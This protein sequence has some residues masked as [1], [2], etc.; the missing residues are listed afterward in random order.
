MFLC[1]FSQCQR[2]KFWAVIHAKHGRIATV[3]RDPVKHPDHSWGW[4]IQIYFNRQR[5]TVKVIN[6]IERAKTTP[7]DQGIMHK[8]NRPA[9]VQRFRRGQ[10]RRVTHRQPLFALT[11]KIQLQQTINTVDPFVIPHVSLPP[12][13]LKK[14]RKTVSWIPFSC[15]LQCGNNGFVTC[16]IRTVMINR[17]AQVQAPAGLTDTESECRYQ[18][19]DQL[20]LKGWF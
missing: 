7:T 10:W 16:V 1:P 11:A 6:D 14:L 15:C 19:S 3:C 2:D 4:Q 13:N 5:L 9:L 12:Q 8:I 20:T 17:S 18:M